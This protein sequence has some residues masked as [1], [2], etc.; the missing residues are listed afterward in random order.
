MRKICGT[1]KTRRPHLGATLKPKMG[2]TDQGAADQFYDAAC[3]DFDTY[4][5]DETYHNQWCSP[6]M[7]RITKVYEALDKAKSE[8]H[9]PEGEMFY[10][11]Q[12]TTDLETT[13]ETAD[14]MIAHGAR[15]MMLNFMCTWYP[16]LRALAEDASINVPI[17]LHRES[18]A[19][20]TRHP[21]HGINLPV[22]D[23]IARIAGGD[24][25]HVGTARGKLGDQNKFTEIPQIMNKI[26]DPLEHIK[27]M[28][29]ICSGGLTPQNYHFSID[30]MGNDIQLQNGGGIHGHPWGTKGG[31][32]SARQ[33]VDAYMQSIPVEEYAKTHEELAGAIQ[34]FG[35]KYAVASEESVVPELAEGEQ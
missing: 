9:H 11:P 5:D 31:A 25:V 33:A 1:T 27:P 21:R 8:G 24:M 3:G 17:H 14:R 29:G 10:V 19:A 15:G 16:A 12:V 34:A 30:L 35:N 23:F 22:T 28:M 32:I 18:H 7:D 26:Q 20:L 6:L 4:K 2:V 13:L